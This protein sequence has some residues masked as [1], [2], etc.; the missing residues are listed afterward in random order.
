MLRGQGEMRKE[1]NRTETGGVEGK[2]REHTTNAL[3]EKSCHV[4]PI[5]TERIYNLRKCSHANCSQ[6]LR[7]PACRVLWT[8]LHQL[9][10]ARLPFLQCL[11]NPA[12]MEIWKARGHLFRQVGGNAHTRARTHKHTANEQ[13][14][15]WCL[16]HWRQ[17]YSTCWRPLWYRWAWINSLTL[18]FYSFKKIKNKN[19]TINH[20]K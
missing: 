11:Y 1:T 7:V 17:H 13:S 10:V 20:V 8:F 3:S 14:L 16:S 4:Y 2:V 6:V 19:N 18:P 15:M 12:T 9:P 5:T